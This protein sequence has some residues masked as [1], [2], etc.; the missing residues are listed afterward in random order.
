MEGEMSHC[1]KWVLLFIGLFSA[2]NLTTGWVHAEERYPQKPIEMIIPYE[3][4]GPT[5]LGIRA[6]GEEVG[7]ILKTSVVSLNKPGG[8]GIFGTAHAVNAKK[9]GYTILGTSTPPITNLP[10][11]KPKEVR[12]DPLKDLEPLAYCASI[13][14]S[15][16][17]RSDSPFKT[18]E[19]LEKYSKENPGKVS[20]GIPGVG[21][22][23]WFVYQLLR[24]RGLEMN[25]IITKGVPQN[26][27]FLLGG[28]IEVSASAFGAEEGHVL[29]GKI[30]TLAIILDRRLPRFPE[31]PTIAEKG[32]PEAAL[33]GWI[34]FFAPKATPKLAVDSL[35]SAFE[36]AMKNPEVR[37]KLEKF[38]LFSDYRT[39]AELS[40]MIVEQQKTVR[41]VAEKTGIIED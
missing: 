15:I 18:F 33:V 20:I 4:G 34:G 25:V 8:G 1:R 3:P 14:A 10:I 31:I 28:H 39:P 22:Q 5:D 11:I 16:S 17:V 40:K 6:V 41:M 21:L 26:T 13:I 36:M 23:P 29:E 2:A 12:Y 30:R 38:T 19:D 32:Y 35:I 9:D 7:R 24:F 27:A 37:D